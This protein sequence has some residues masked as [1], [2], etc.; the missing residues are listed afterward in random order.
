MEENKVLDT[1]ILIPGERGL[2][3]IINILEY[4]PALDKCHAI[5]PERQDFEMA[6]NIAIMLRDAGNPIP[7]SDIVISSI[8]INRDL[9]LKTTD[10]H[11]NAVKSIF[12]SF[13]LEIKN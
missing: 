2:T 7:V 1:N 12:P 4:P 6:L 13:K 8:C 11:F 3:T 9:T 5:I 10:S